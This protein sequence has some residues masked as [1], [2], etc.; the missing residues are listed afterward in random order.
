[1]K[2]L[3]EAKQY[4][5]RRKYQPGIT[6]CASLFCFHYSDLLTAFSIYHRRLILFTIPS[7]YQYLVFSSPLTSTT[8][9]A[10][11][12]GNQLPFCSDSTAVM[13]DFT[14]P[15]GFSHEPF[16]RNIFIMELANGDSQ[17]SN[18]HLIPSTIPTAF[19]L[20]SFPTYQT[21]LTTQTHPTAIYH[22]SRVSFLIQSQAPLY[23]HPWTLSNLT[24]NLP[25]TFLIG[26]LKNCATPSSILLFYRF[27]IGQKSTKPH[28][29]THATFIANLLGI[30]RNTR[31][32]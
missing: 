21:K 9:P 30:R 26:I 14:V 32:P 29:S 10:L 12:L 3:S 6:P 1:M 24:L 7:I 4:C 23:K 28:S 31:S 19:S 25:N 5:T 17:K 11:S 18:R 15:D 2:N 27:I 20:S 22:R 16:H 8:I 13:D